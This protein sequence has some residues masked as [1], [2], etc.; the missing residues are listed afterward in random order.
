LSNNLLILRQRF[1]IKSIMLKTRILAILIVTFSVVLSS[2]SFYIWQ[3]VYTPNVLIDQEDR[4]IAIYPGTTF[5][6]LQDMVHEERIVRDLI[7]FSVLAKFMNYDSNIKT[8]LYSLKREMSNYEAIKVLR[9]GAQTPVNITFN[10]IRLLDELPPKI[11][12][13]L[14]L[15][16]NELDSLLRDPKTAESYGFTPETFISMFIPNTYEVYWTSS[17]MELLDRMYEEYNKFWNEERKAK[18]DSLDLTPQQV[19]TLASIVQAETLKKEES[20]TIA[21]VYLNR[22]KKR[23]ALQAD[24]TL[25]YAL[26]DFTIKRVLNE[27]KEIDSPYNTYKY[28]GLPPG[29][30]NMP[31]IHSIDAVLNYEK[32]SFYYFCA[33]EDFS[34]NHNFSANLNE[35]LRNARLYQ[36]AL[37]KAKLYR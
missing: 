19:S 9:N 7:S 27:H 1:W 25:V 3:M 11:C 35:H 4:I 12:A 23:I 28:R 24:P 5:E 30:I 6:D 26:G 20:A 8:G 2:T 36:A 18:A 10:T 16:E 17:A 31:G 15:K 21:G 34:G 32:H 29:P 13:N 22:L 14:A 33:K 37:N